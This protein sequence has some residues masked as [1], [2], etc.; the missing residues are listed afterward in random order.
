MK[1][2][3]NF[4]NLNFINP[5]ASKFDTRAVNEDI[6]QETNGKICNVA[7]TVPRKK[8]EEGREYTYQNI[9]IQIPSLLNKSMNHI[10]VFEKICARY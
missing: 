8:N 10:L 2:Y 5:N 6:Q 4:H 7:R 1:V 9:T 3:K